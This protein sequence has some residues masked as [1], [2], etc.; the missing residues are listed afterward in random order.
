MIKPTTSAL[1]YGEFYKTLLDTY[2][3]KQWV[4]ISGLFVPESKAYMAY[5]IEID[6]NRSITVTYDRD[7]Q[8]WQINRGQAPGW[9]N[10]V[11]GPTLEAAKEEYFLEASCK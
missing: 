6:P 9:E 4:L 11:S 7:S 1:T 3:G 8:F 2:P 10:R 5:S